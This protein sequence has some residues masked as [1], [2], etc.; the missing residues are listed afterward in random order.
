MVKSFLD[1][2]PK[3]FAKCPNC[4]SERTLAEAMYPLMDPKKRP[5]TPDKLGLAPMFIEIE[6]PIIPKAVQFLLDACLDC[7]TYYVKDIVL[8]QGKPV[9][10]VPQ[11]D[12]Q[13]NRAERRRE[14]LGRT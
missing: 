9:G 11:A 1:E 7:G 5:P 13:P 12:P 10:V 4:G 2:L 3:T 6:S 14:Q 8:L